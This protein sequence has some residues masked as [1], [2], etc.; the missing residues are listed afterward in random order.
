MPGGW[1][2]VECFRELGLCL[3]G[4]AK[5][6]YNILIARDYPNNADR[7]AAGTFEELKRK[8]I[9]KLFDHTYPGDRMY[10]YLMT[11][12][13]YMRYKKDDGRQEEPIKVLA[14]LQRLRKMGGDDAPQP[15]RKVYQ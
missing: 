11:K 13:Q 4:D 5:N 14:R 7:N 12:I 2:G 8:I 10:T 9:T 3:S 15:W 1:N 6:E